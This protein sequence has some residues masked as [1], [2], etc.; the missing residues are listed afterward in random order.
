MYKRIC[1][2]IYEWVFMYMHVHM[3]VCRYECVCAGNMSQ[4]MYGGNAGVSFHLPAWLRQEPLWFTNIG[5]MLV[6]PDFW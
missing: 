1:I 2:F 6:S 3:C 5:H 4:H